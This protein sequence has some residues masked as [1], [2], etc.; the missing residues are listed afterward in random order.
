MDKEE[1]ARALDR[2]RKEDDFG[3]NDNHIRWIEL[4]EEMRKWT[5]F[6]MKSFSSCY[7]QQVCAAGS[8]RRLTLQWALERKAKTIWECSECRNASL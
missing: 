4:G 8:I 6:G 2:L 7:P 3:L 5:F 1:I